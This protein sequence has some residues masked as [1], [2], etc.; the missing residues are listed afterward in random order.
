MRIITIIDAMVRIMKK[1]YDFYD[2]NSLL[3]PGKNHLEA[4][5]QES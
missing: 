3:A 5:L 4:D 1:L 2:F